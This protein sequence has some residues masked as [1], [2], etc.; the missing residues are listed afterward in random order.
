MSWYWYLLIGFGLYFCAGVVFYVWATY[1]S[2]KTKHSLLAAHWGFCP[3]GIKFG[4]PCKK[5][6]KGDMIPLYKR[7]KAGK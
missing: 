1:Q 4:E 7:T 6:E 5:C 2:V 3:H